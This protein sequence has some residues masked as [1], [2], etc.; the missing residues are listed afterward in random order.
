[1]KVGFAETPSANS[2]KVRVN[3]FS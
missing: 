3:Y 2:C 1:M